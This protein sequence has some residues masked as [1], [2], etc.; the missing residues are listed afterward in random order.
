MPPS[1][2]YEIL[3][4]KDTSIAAGASSVLNM[5]I[6]FQGALIA[7]A[8]EETDTAG[9]IFTT[10]LESSNGDILIP[11]TSH[12]KAVFGTAERP[13]FLPRPYPVKTSTSLI[14]TVTNSSAATGKI[15]ITA[16]FTRKD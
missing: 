12:Y 16:Y 1:K 2:G 6:G 15:Y 5:A 4:E 3:S 13:F 7:L 11:A 14:F 8:I 10:K 9:G